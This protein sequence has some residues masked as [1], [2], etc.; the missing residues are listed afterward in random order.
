M[1][2]SSRCLH[3]MLAAKTA[4]TTFG[5]APSF[6]VPDNLGAEGPRGGLRGHFN[7]RADVGHF[8]QPPRDAPQT[9]RALCVK[10]SCVTRSIGHKTVV[11]SSTATWEE[12][13]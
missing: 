2:M 6:V 1:L 5:G 3:W 7:G 11:S 8:S 12:I 10:K 4:V 9:F 13:L